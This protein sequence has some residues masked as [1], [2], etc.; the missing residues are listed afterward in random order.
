MENMTHIPKKK[1]FKRIM[2]A[3][4]FKH[5]D[6]LLGLNISNNDE[7]NIFRSEDQSE[8]KIY[9]FI[10]LL[11]IILILTNHTKENL[12]FCLATRQF[13]HLLITIFMDHLL[14]SIPNIYFSSKYSNKSI[15]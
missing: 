9:I 12:S 6:F 4:C 5:E 1:N 11:S 14:N 15:S 10:F 7:N 13:F 8:T 3:F 2:L